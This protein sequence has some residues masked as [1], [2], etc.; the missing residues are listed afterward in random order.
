MAVMLNAERNKPPVIV[1]P[2]LWLLGCVLFLTSNL[3]TQTDSLFAP[4]YTR[5]S[6]EHYNMCGFMITCHEYHHY[7]FRGDTLVNGEYCQK[8]YHATGINFD[9]TCLAYF[10]YL[11]T[12]NKKVYADTTLLYDFNLNAGDTFNLYV[13]NQIHNGYYKMPV[14]YTDSMFYGNRWRKRI[15][16]KQMPGFNLNAIRWVEGIGDIDY[17]ST[18]ST[19]TYGFIEH[20][21]NSGSTGYFRLNCFQEQGYASYG[22][23]CYNGSCPANTMMVHGE[24]NLTI[25]PN[26]ASQC[27]TVSGGPGMKLKLCDVLGREWRRV[28]GMD[29]KIT[30]DVSD[31]PNAFYFLIIE[32]NS[33]FLLEKVVVQH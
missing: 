31:L 29:G 21:Y 16:F 9:T 18:Y 3:Y 26:P 33:S 24:I 25:Q 13:S 6:T 2:K 7:S 23:Y 4:N 1:L 22:T 14:D 17:G 15:V 19:N 28:E 27:L 10:T 8:L 5:W 12:E 32:F 30:I 11:H 20:M